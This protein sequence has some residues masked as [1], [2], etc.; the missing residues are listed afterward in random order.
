[1]F[2][3]MAPK[4]SFTLDAVNCGFHSQMGQCRDGNFS[5]SA[6]QCNCPLWKPH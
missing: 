3:E 1:M 6:Q 2:F 5:I 4:G